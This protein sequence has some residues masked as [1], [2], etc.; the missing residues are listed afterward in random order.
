M[1]RTSLLR[2]LEAWVHD[3]AQ[4]DPEPPPSTT[5]GWRLVYIADC[6]VTH[7]EWG[8]GRG[9]DFPDLVPRRR[10]RCKPAAAAA[11][12]QVDA[13]PATAASEAIAP[14]TSEVGTEVEGRWRG[15]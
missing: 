12:E 15:L 1:S 6:K 14:P 7:H 2:Q 9:A 4:P 13:E 8:S 11:A 3:R 10:R 5:I